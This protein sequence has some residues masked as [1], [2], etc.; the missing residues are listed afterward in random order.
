L[1]DDKTL[2]GWKNDVV[3][4]LA[5]KRDSTISAGCAILGLRKPV[6]DTLTS[7]GQM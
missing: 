6:G 1:S 5:N 4:M 3:P 2:A 7:A